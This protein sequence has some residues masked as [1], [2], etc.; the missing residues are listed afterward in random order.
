MIVFKPALKK[1]RVA[2]RRSGRANGIR[3]TSPQSTCRYARTSLQTEA[4]RPHDG[5]DHRAVD[6]LPN[7]AHAGIEHAPRSGIEG[8]L[9][10]ASSHMRRTG[11]L[12]STTSRCQA[13][14][15][16][17]DS[18][19]AVVVAPPARGRLVTPRHPPVRL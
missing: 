17:P 11:V 2:S 8:I 19:S 7:P 6:G 13:A 4:F 14:S 5:I 15:D 10:R 16:R 9:L 12:W 1:S 3:R 18:A